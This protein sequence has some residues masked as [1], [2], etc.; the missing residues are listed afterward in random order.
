MAPKPLFDLAVR[1]LGLFFLYHALSAIPT[2][3]QVFI[4]AVRQLNWGNIIG[5]IVAIAWP[6]AL[7]YWLMRGAAPL[8]RI[9]FPEEKQ[10]T[11]T[12]APVWK[13]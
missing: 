9:A 5:I 4:P 13:P 11:P 7:S 6:L 1:V 10:P 12:D 3:L 8:V 2:A